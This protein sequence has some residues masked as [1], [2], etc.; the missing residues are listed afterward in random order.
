MVILIH[1]F[2]TV[3][4]SV[5]IKKYSSA[6]SDSPWTLIVLSSH[7]SAHPRNAFPSNLTVQPKHGYMVYLLADVQV[8]TDYLLFTE[9]QVS[10]TL[11]L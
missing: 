11:L 9:T 7:A 6:P 8:Q 2:Q 1:L 5:K 10:T 4:I 3:L